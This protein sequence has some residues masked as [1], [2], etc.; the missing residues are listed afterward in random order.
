V[1]LLS[2][3][4]AGQKPSL[5]LAA[6]L[7]TPVSAG[8]PPAPAAA[9]AQRTQMPAPALI[10]GHGAG[11]RRARH[12]AFCREACKRGFVVLA[13][14]FRGHGDSGGEADGPMEQDILTAARF[15]RAQ[16][17]VDPN[18]LCY[19]GSSMGGFYGLK[20]APQAGFVA[21]VLLCPAGEDVVLDAI[22]ASEKADSG[23]DDA[24]TNGAVLDGPGANGAASAVP[25][26]ADPPRWDTP[27]L[28]PYFER[29]DSGR[30]AA[31]VECPVLLVHARQD[32][33]VPFNHSL[34]LV[35]RL[36]TET[37]LLALEGGT[38]TTA[39]HD[40]RIHRLTIAWLHDQMGSARPGPGPT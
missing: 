19:R 2:A 8:R 16:P 12:E 36:R 3:V 4:D 1:I 25:E 14:D 31:Q 34:M 26:G 23:A 10:V 27:R 11:S 32:N 39:Q 29:Q 7:Y 40:P 21:M 6:T 17:A 13:L 30:L 33:V 5:E 20:A 28:R 38:H 18:R 9:S 37:T 22:A 35:E 15:L 24:T